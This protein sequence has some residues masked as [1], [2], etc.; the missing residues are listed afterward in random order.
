VDS[1]IPDVAAT[2]GS[3][4]EVRLCLDECRSIFTKCG[5]DYDP[6]AEDRRR[7][8]LLIDCQAAGNCYCTE[9]PWRTGSPLAIDFDKADKACSE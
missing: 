5:V 6:I 3:S 7:D 9:T 4:D 1:S 8:V 2:E